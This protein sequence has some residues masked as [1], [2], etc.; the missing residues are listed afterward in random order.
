MKVSSGTMV[1]TPVSP[2]AVFVDDAD[3]TSE[4]LD[5]IGAAVPL[6]VTRPGEV[7]ATVP[8]LG[9]GIREEGIVALAS[10]M[11]RSWVSMLVAV[12]LVAGA[13]Q[14]VKSVKDLVALAKAKPGQLN[15]AS[16]GSGASD[17]MMRRNFP[18][19][20]NTWIR[21]LVRSAT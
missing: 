10:I 17:V 12:L 11:M 4:Y 3:T 8:L 15:F 13:D 18:S 7:V 1:C 2:A 19:A 9:W 20:S 5:E 6:L 14:P 21:R 16:A